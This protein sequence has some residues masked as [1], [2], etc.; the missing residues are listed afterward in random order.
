[1]FNFA[2]SLTFG[3]ILT[4]PLIVALLCFPSKIT[5]FLAAFLFFIAGLT[6]FF[7]G[8]I[9][10][11]TNQ[12]TNLGKFL[13]PLAD[14]LLICS[15]LIMLTELGLV[16]GWITVVIV[17]RELAVTG[18][19]AIASDMGMVLAADKLGK[20]KTLMQSLALGPLLLHYQYIGM[21]MHQVGTMILYVAV[22][23]TVVSGA[24]YMYNLH[25][26]WLTSE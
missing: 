17:C 26:V 22:V 11:R 20:L 4:I 14:K 3:R 24:N 18:L 1:M 5:M 13:D 19:R 15:V 2:N 7:D 25:K 10:R 9:A 8:Y 23:L 12:V 16:S 6:D 21:D